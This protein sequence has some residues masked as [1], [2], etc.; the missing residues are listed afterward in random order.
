N[1]FNEGTPFVTTCPISP[2]ASYTYTVP[3]TDQAGTFWYH[4]PPGSDGSPL[5]RRQR[6]YD[7]AS[8]RLVAQH[9]H[10]IACRICRHWY[11]SSIR[12]WHFQ[13]RWPFPRRPSSSILRSERCSWQAL[14][15]PH[16]QPV[17]PKCL[18]H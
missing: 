15:V 4:R 17:C 7:L 10:S 9:N 18:H 11:R 1:A 3:L 13:W 12:L 14:Q 6:E 2:G 16:H 8:R 5:R